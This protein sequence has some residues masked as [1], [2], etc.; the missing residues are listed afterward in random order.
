M[1]QNFNS[2]NGRCKP[3]SA[4]VQLLKAALFLLSFLVLSSLKGNS[5][6][7]DKN[8][9]HYP[10]G[11]V[12]V[13]SKMTLPPVRID[14]VYS[15]TVHRRGNI[16]DLLDIRNISG[17]CDNITDNNTV[18]IAD[19]TV[20]LQVTKKCNY[21]EDNF[22]YFT[23]HAERSP[24]SPDNLDFVVPIIRDTLKMVLTLDISGSMS[25]PVELLTGPGT[26]TRL[27]ALKHAVSL[28]TPKLEELYKDGDS[29]GITYF[30]S[31]VYQP[32]TSYFPKDFISTQTCGGNVTSDLGP[33]V[34]MQMTGMANGL[35]DAKAKLIKN[36]NKSPYT[37]KV[38]F[39][40]TDGLQNWGPQVKDD[41]NS[42][43][44]VTDSLNNKTTPKDSIRYYT[45][46]TWQAGLAP[47]I[48]D[49]IAKK[50][51]GEALHVVNTIYPLENWFNEQLT[52]ILDEGSPQIV[53]NSFGENITSPKSYSFELNNN[54]PKLL[55]ELSTGKYSNINLEIY[56]DGNN[57]TSHA[58]QKGSAYYNIWIFDFPQAQ[59]TVMNSGGT[60]TIKLSGNNPHH[61][62][63]AVIAD[64][65]FLNYKCKL[66]NTIY[67]VGD[68]LK[69]SAHMTYL[70]KPL[71]G[72]TNSVQAVLFKPGDDIGELLSEYPT[73]A[74]DT[75]DLG[76]P[77]SAK[78]ESL[79]TNDTSFY[80]ALLPDE[81]I[82][83]LISNENGLFTGEYTN[84]NLT[85]I[86]NVIFLLNGELA[87]VGKFERTKIV[88]SVFKF[89]QVVPQAPD[90]SNSQS[91]STT[92][93]TSTGT[94]G[95][96]PKNTMVTVIP[97]NIFG[98][99][100]GPGFASKIKVVVNPGKP[101]KASMISLPG[102][103]SNPAIN[104]IA[105]NLDGSYTINISGIPKTSNP[106][107]QIS[108]MDE[109]LYKGKM[110]PV[111]WWY[112]L[113]LAL[114]IIL[115][116]LASYFRITNNKAYKTIIWLLSLLILLII[117]LHRIGIIKLF[118]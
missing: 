3:G 58:R 69:I 10:D 78:F 60:W 74:P 97:K 102:E 19:S 50:G 15:F 6:I 52:N 115:L 12:Y 8:P 43:T 41:G 100:M 62:N 82:I 37:T 84:T 93:S 75:I 33:Q 49:S 70:G 99:R 87:D 103:K 98:N 107:I 77:A 96:Q 55:V 29:L 83:N 90:V 110:W 95:T 51:H 34:P 39:L 13:S 114:L 16:P 76:S 80:N 45:V 57:V 116:L 106:I 1:N 68:T 31:V 36:K 85:G 59:D 112:Y 71:T 89:G 11:T 67:T 117:I 118:I 40:F 109:P 4:P 20:T 54:I 56:K 26:E 53:F 104:E 2:G 28:M 88:S 23:V 101:Q 30:S 24:G 81:Q 46:A 86:Y 113:I 66:D 108:V 21:D 65:H 35:L 9:D 94:S 72:S 44:I 92:T 32:S 61:F 7:L 17:S 48:L 25:L 111:P 14:Q 63:L 64:D 42:V 18:S 38:V 79:M 27:D 91:T 105:D 47:F 73:P 22:L 5:Q